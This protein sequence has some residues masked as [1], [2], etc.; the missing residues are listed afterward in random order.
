[1]S[2]SKRGP[3]PGEALP[4]QDAID[5]FLAQ[6]KDTSAASYWSNLKVV[7]E[8]IGA[9]RLIEDITA[10]D[11]GLVQK[12][13]NNPGRN[14][15]DA[16]RTKYIKVMK[17]FFNW[18][19]KNNFL[20]GSPAGFLKVPKVNPYVD[21]EKAMTDE[22]L[23]KLLDYV[24]W[25]PRD[26]A[27]VLFLA[28]TGAR[29]G[30]ASGL[31]WQDIDF[32]ELRAIVTEKGDKSRPVAFGDLCASALKAWLIRRPKTAGLY[33]F[34]ATKTPI[35]APCI[36]QIITRACVRAGVRPLGSHSLRHRKGHQF[37][38]NR[39]APPTAAL[40]MGHTDVNVTMGSYYPAGWARTDEALRALA[41]K[42][43]SSPAA[44]TT[45]PPPPAPEAPKEPRQPPKL[46]VLRRPS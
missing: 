31:R 15:A 5:L 25:K 2:S 41:V 23:R 45:P 13:I 28:D 35:K 43:I 18:L 34:S 17:T 30:G 32:E 1:M 36:S 37:A 24:K 16:T 12:Y 38:E 19:V 21:P 42:S 26:Y 46:I 3:R 11:I 9:K 22:E 8:I 29:A 7:A 20:E 33:V 44:D 27:L 14:Y 4:L 40:A 6:H 39:I 10:K